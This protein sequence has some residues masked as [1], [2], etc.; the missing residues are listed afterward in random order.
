MY[1]LAHY[2][3]GAALLRSGKPAEAIPE[4][5]QAVELAPR[6]AMMHYELGIA[7][8]RNGQ[9][10]AGDAEFRTAREVDPRWPAAARE[11]A[12]TL[13]THPDR[14]GRNGA[15]AVQ[16]AQHACAVAQYSDPFLLDTL[17]AAQAESGQFEEAA[18]TMRRALEYKAA[19][20]P[21]LVRPMEERLRLYERR[22]PFHEP[23][24]S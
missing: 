17:A 15:L 7:L 11:A 8:F 4:L 13:A 5:T 24:T 23:T 10:T 1:A 3:L 19:L 20:P 6:T 9:Q 22:Q 2:H 12:W 21:D 14:Q 16:L 18:K